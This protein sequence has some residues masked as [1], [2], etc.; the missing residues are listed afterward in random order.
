MHIALIPGTY[1]WDWNHLLSLSYK[2]LKNGVFSE[3][4]GVFSTGLFMGHD[5]LEARP[6]VALTDIGKLGDASTESLC[7]EISGSQNNGSAE[8]LSCLLPKC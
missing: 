5:S 6:R 3:A 7:V 1:D 4:G 8:E 2:Q